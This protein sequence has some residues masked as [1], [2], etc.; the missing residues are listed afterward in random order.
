MGENWRIP[1]LKKLKHSEWTR[2]PNSYLI[3]VTKLHFNS[4]NIALFNKLYQEILKRDHLYTRI[5]RTKCGAISTQKPPG[6]ALRQWDIR[7]WGLF[8]ELT[9]INGDGCWRI[10]VA[11]G[12]K[13]DEIG[14]DKPI[15]SG[16]QAFYKFRDI[17]R[18]KFD[19]DL[20]TYAIEDGEVVNHTIEKPLIFLFDERHNK[21]KVFMNA[22][23]IDFH[24][25]YPA[26]LANTHPEFKEAITYFY[27]NRYLHPSFK[28]ILNFS[29]G[30]F[31]SKFVGYKF[32]HLAK[33]AISDSN[34]RVRA[35]AGRVQ[36]AG[37]K[38]IL[39]NTDG[40]WYTGEIFHGAGEGKNLGQWH[41]DH[42][43]CR[44]RVKSAGAYEFIENETY[45]PVLRGFTEL[46]KIKDRGN[47]SW[48]DIYQEN[49]EIKTYKF[50]E[51]EGFIEQ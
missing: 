7:Q 44:L 1:A 30:F 22:H 10:Q 27:E 4:D 48:G 29:V 13:S 31:H 50:V 15:Y 6:A 20:E 49:A 36:R 2:K 45:T 47:W 26:G 24:N 23:H 12:K 42:I 46:D 18:E 8:T 41:N 14:G 37:G 33:D 19:I 51:G 25:S 40:F 43:N 34:A 5:I 28:D 32:A 39:Y 16:R 9:I 17:L 21:D 3:P 38:I 11:P 35:L